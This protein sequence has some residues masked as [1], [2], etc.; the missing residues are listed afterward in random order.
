[1]KNVKLT[2]YNETGGRNCTFYILHCTF[3]TLR[4]DARDAFERLIG[5]VLRLG[6][7][8][9]RRILTVHQTA[10]FAQLEGGMLCAATGFF[11]ALLWCRL[12]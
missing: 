9:V 10:H 2:M 11:P 3:L 4:L 6:R 8:S 5:L 12:L 1:M 7:R